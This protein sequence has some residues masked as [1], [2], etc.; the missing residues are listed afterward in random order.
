M[1]KIVST[2]ALLVLSLISIS[3]QA[4][5]RIKEAV[6]NPGRSAA[7]LKRDQ[8]SKPLEILRFIGV[9]EKMVVADVFSSSG[10]Y[11][12]LLSYIVGP[13]GKVYAHNNQSYV[14]FLGEEKLNKRY[15]DDRL[16]NVTQ[17]F[18]EPADLKLPNGKLDLALM[19]MTFHDLYFSSDGWPKIEP[20]RL[21]KQLYAS[22][23]P[24]GLLLILDHAARK[25][26]AQSDAQNL[27]R[28]EEAFTRT[29]FKSFGFKWVKDSQVLRNPKDNK[30]ITVF[31]PS[32]RG[33]TDRFVLLFRR[34]L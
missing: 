6:E 19:V 25:G 27:H 1:S 30:A 11:S 12:E 17:L 32:V 7:D 9:K 23:K 13:A 18:S 33:T 10:Y 8:R 26:S 2:L 31:D 5:D 24:G 28:I 21:I 15:A 22:L 20:A 34:P 29:T 4:Q 3:L 14:A 16:A